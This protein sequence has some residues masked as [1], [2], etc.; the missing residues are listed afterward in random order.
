MEQERAFESKKFRRAGAVLGI[1]AA[2]AIGAFFAQDNLLD[3]SGQEQS[4]GCTIPN[5]ENQESVTHTVTATTY[6]IGETPSED[7]GQISNIP[8][9]WESNSVDV[10]GGVDNPAGRD[11][12]P[13]HNTYYF[14]LPAGEFNSHELIEGAR[15]QSPWA[16]E[17]NDLAEDES[18]FKGKWI[19]ICHEDKVAYAQWHDVGP[20]VN[21]DYEYVFGSAEPKNSIRQQAGLDL[22]PDAAEA[23]GTS[24]STTVQWRFIDESDVPDGAWQEYSPI[25]N[26][27]N[28]N[29]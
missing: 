25:T 20:F 24:G 19:E 16:D 7:N 29:P 3:T 12:T 23:L 2:L 17:S 26:K 1:S 8:S 11:F 5:P 18:L 28:W 9:Q 22:S 21:D 27:T 14:A 10:F 6:W 13:N 4:T 15:E